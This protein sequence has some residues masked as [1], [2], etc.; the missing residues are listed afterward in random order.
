MSPARAPRTV[1]VTGDVTMDWNVLRSRTAGSDGA[2]WNAR[3]VARACW[4]RGGALLLAD[5]VESIAGAMSTSGPRIEIRQP[6]V[7]REGVCPDDPRFHH[8]YAIWAP[9]PPHG[10]WRV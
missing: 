3:D 5:I 1:V 6:A 8:S 7:P 9:V 4:Q 10:A 2:T